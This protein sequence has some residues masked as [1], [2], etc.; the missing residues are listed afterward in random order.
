MKKT[1]YIKLLCLVIAIG[2]V[3]FISCVGFGSK[4]VGSYK[5]ISLGLD[6]AGGVSITYQA[7]KD[8]PTPEEMEDARYKLE[9]CRRQEHGISS[10]HRGHEP[11]QC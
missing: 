5:D 10:V 2:V 6:L 9:A 4:A 3:A 7:V 8:D 11:Y 1:G